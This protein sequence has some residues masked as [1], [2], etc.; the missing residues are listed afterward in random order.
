[1]VEIERMLDLHSDI[2]R[3]FTVKHFHEQ[4]AKRHNYVLRYTVT[5]LHLQRAAL[6]YR[7]KMRPAPQEAAAP[8][9]GGDGAAPGRLD[10]R[11]AAWGPAQV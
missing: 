10:A 7:A 2:Y 8:A 3:S 9:D 4:L 1:V 5:K 11:L 6:V